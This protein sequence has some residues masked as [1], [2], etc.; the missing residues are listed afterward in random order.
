MREECPKL[1]GIATVGE[2]ASAN[3]EEALKSGLEG[4]EADELEGD[5][6]ALVVIID[7]T[8]AE[9]DEYCIKKE[10]EFVEEECLE[11]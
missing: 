6:R 5:M 11:L 4:S 9:G 10:A 1:E 8:G 7:V 3:E 2:G